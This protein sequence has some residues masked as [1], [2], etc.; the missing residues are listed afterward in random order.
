MKKKL[1]VGLISIAVLFLLIQVKR[2]ERTNPP[3]DPT[4]TIQAH[5]QV[6]QEINSLI[7]RSCKDCHSNNTVW[8]WYTNIAPASWLVA[9]DVME[10]RRHLNFSEWGNYKKNKQGKRL[11]QIYEEVTGKSMPLSVYLP[12]HPEAK[13][14]EQDRAMF[15]AWA[16]KEFEK[17]MGS[18]S[19]I[20]NGTDDKK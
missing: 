19:E 13:L 17:M 9:S 1:Q 6:P 15:G 2:P 20:E 12:L 10:G 11:S 5:I 16:Q 8:P 18:D 7:D 3:V 4:K 14:T